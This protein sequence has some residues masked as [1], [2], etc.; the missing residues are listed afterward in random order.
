MVLLSLPSSGCLCPACKVYE[1]AGRT[2]G[3]GSSCA[4]FTGSAVACRTRL[5]ELLLHGPQPQQPLGRASSL[6]ENGVEANHASANGRSPVPEGGSAPSMTQ[7]SSDAAA[8]GVAC[9]LLLSTRSYWLSTHLM[10]Y[11]TIL[12]CFAEGLGA[13]VRRAYALSQHQ[14]ELGCEVLHTHVLLLM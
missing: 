7:H 13:A 10:Q 8:R 4:T 2:G 5:Q 12:R 14:E 9:K 3:I 11:A 1:A 6:L